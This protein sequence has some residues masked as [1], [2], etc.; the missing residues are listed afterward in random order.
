[1]GGVSR[2]LIEP[3]WFIWAI[4]CCLLYYKCFDILFSQYLNMA[5]LAVISWAIL[6][7]LPHTIE[8]YLISKVQ[9]L[10]PF[11]L[12][13]IIFRKF[14][15]FEKI[16]PYSLI[17]VFLCIVILGMLYI[18]F[19]PNQY[20]YHFQ[21]MD[22]TVW[23]LSYFM[24]LLAGLAGIII[25]FFISKKLSHLK[26]SS[27]FWLNEIGQFTLAIYLEQTVVFS[28]LNYTG[29]KLSNDLEVFILA[30]MI[31]LCLSFLTKIISQNKSLSKILLGK[32]KTE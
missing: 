15:L 12:T 13:G 32:I 23:L 30:V 9:S 19:K 31:Y 17:S 5:Y 8:S 27:I 24:M 25:C 2:C 20:F 10:Y 29:A 18:V 3:Y 14:R 26:N 4:I 28:F 1:M 6:M 22:T 21:Y 11:F 16:S 7:L